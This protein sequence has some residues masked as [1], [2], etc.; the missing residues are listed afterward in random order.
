MMKSTYISCPPV[1]GNTLIDE[2]IRTSA[3]LKMRLREAKDDRVEEGRFERAA[4][5]YIQAAQ[6]KTRVMDYIEALTEES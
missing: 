4:T 1:D 6:A 5:A 3:N 2:L